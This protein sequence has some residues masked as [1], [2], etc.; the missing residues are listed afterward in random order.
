MHAPHLLRDGHAVGGLHVELLGQVGNRF[1]AAGM[2]THDL[3]FL[4]GAELPPR[5]TLAHGKFLRL[6]LC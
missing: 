3:C 4:R 6:G 2:P 5:L 1:L